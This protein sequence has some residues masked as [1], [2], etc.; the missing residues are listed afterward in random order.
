MHSTHALALQQLEALVGVEAGVVQQRGGAAQPGGDERVAGGLR[1]AAGRRAPR[2]L[3]LA[4][5]EP[6]LGL[7]PLAGQ[8]ALAVADR[9]GSP[10][11]PEVNTISA[12]SSA[13]RSTAGAGAESSRLGSGTSRIVPPKPAS[14]TVAASRSS[15][16]TIAGSA[17][18]IRARRSAGRSCS[19]QGSATAPIRQHASIASTHSGRLPIAVITTLPAPTPWEASVP[20]SRAARASTSPNVSS[21]REPS[22]ASATSALR[23]G[24]A[25]PTTSLVKFNARP[26]AGARRRAGGRGPATQLHRRLDQPLPRKLFTGHSPPVGQR[27]CRADDHLGDHRDPLL[28]AR[29]V[30]VARPGA[31]ILGDQLGNQRGDSGGHAVEH[32][33]GLGVGGLAEEHAPG[34]APLLHEGEDRVEAGLQA[35]GGVGAPGRGRGRDPLEELAGVH[36]DQRHVQ[37]LLGR[38]VLV[39]QG[40]G[41]PRRLGNLVNRRRV[42]AAGREHLQGGLQDLRAARLGGQPASRGG[43]SCHR[44]I[45]AHARKSL[46]LVTIHTPSAHIALQTSHSRG[47]LGVTP[48][49]SCPMVC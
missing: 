15:A 9:L 30:G 49:K 8:V 10:A 41:D 39:D 5:A 33:R 35:L 22:R 3:A 11:V 31:G 17:A 42:V 29:A 47:D 45:L 23:D 14:R 44:G 12:G 43:G 1:P 24:S 19:V 34:A 28:A 40:L 27:L 6:V 4:R 37:L 16:I 18:S 32:G 36:L 21:A 46:Q 48:S 2:E 38:E 26:R 13:A 25:A 7:D 20:A